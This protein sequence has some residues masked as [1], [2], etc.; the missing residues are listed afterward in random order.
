[1]G[2]AVHTSEINNTSNSNNK[3]PEYARNYK[4]EWLFISGINKSCGMLITKIVNS[5]YSDEKI[6]SSPGAKALVRDFRVVLGFER[7]GKLKNISGLKFKLSDVGNIE[8]LAEEL[9]NYRDLYVDPGSYVFDEESYEKNIDKDF[10]GFRKLFDTICLFND[11][12]KR[13]EE[14]YI[15]SIFASDES[16]SESESDESESD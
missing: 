16:E 12:I 8:C 15:G 14:E 4:K 6:F 9:D 5:A 3:I 2:S 1:M 13:D 11:K 10:P 7:I